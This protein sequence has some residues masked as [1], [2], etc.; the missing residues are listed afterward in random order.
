MSERKQ[1]IFEI[2]LD[3]H[4]HDFS[5]AL[6]YKK[7]LIVEDVE[8]NCVFYVFTLPFCRGTIEIKIREAS[9]N[10][11]CSICS[12]N[13]NLFKKW[14][15]EGI[16]S[17][18]KSYDFMTTRLKKISKLEMDNSK[19]LWRRVKHDKDTIDE[20]VNQINDFLE[21]LISSETDLEAFRFM[22]MMKNDW[23]TSFH[24]CEDGSEWNP[25]SPSEDNSK[26]PNNPNNSKGPNDS[27][28][29]VSIS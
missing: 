19:V 12:D 26:G 9:D 1:S 14:K 23:P 11:E 22:K 18:K 25:E 27:E 10:P 4:L 16:T 20:A 21:N 29:P 7:M 15:N 5:K 8:R 13:G 28:D 3:K 2:E 24:T 6:D 17:D